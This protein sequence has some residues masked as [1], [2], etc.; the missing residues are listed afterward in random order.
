MDHLIINTFNG[1]I[2]QKQQDCYL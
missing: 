1:S 2:S